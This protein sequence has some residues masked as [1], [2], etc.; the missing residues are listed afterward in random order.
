MQKSEME[1]MNGSEHIQQKG[2]KCLNSGTI[3]RL[4]LRRA[5]LFS[6]V[7]KLLLYLTENK[8]LKHLL[9]R[10]KIALMKGSLLGFS[11]KN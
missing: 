5:S 6:N 8:K 1:R 9:I 4:S 3:F 10:S 11:N 2:Q 7:E